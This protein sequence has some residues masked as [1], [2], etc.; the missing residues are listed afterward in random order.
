MF[1]RLFE[2]AERKFLFTIYF[3]ILKKQVFS[4]EIEHGSPYT[5]LIK[6][7]F[8]EEAEE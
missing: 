2:T 7:K 6:S 3:N 1:L 4:E 8:L 5:G